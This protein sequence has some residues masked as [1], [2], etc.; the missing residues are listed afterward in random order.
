MRLF[1]FLSLSLTPQT[2]GTCLVSAFFLKVQMGVD[3][4]MGY[5]DDSGVQ[6]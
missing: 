3:V 6:S 4:M 2:L 5:V 1:L